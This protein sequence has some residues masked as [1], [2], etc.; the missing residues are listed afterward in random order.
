MIALFDLKLNDIGCR[1]YETIAKARADLQAQL[2]TM[3]SAGLDPRHITTT[4]VGAYFE[5]YRGIVNTTKTT[6]GQNDQGFVQKMMDKF[7]ELCT[8]FASLI[9]KPNVVIYSEQRLLDKAEVNVSHLDKKLRAG[10]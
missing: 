1:S 2:D 7:I 8:Q 9:A 10:M 3:L 6:L 5:A 4:Q